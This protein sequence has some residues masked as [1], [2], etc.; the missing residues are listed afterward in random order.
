MTIEI[1]KQSDVD[2]D[3]QKQV[4]ELMVQLLPDKK[5]IELRKLLEEK[6]QITI[7]YCREN[8]KIVGIAS[9]CN[10]VVISGNK[11]WIEDV[12]VDTKARGKGV[13]QKLIE[14]L[15]E[16]AETLQLSEVL[17]FTADHRTAAIK[18]YT[19]LGFKQKN[20]RVYILDKNKN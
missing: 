14:K 19:K 8:E 4:S 16:V 17:L 3:F 10:Y 5:Q 6:N 15:L 20:S 2:E 7:V 9:M 13:G 18:L 1:L 12:V 11:G